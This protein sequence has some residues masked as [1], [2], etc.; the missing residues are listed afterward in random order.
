[1]LPNL[2]DVINSLSGKET[3]I[4]SEK[5][6]TIGFQW[7]GLR[8]VDYTK[9]CSCTGILGTSDCPT[10]SRCMSTGYLHVDYLVKGYMWLGVLGVEYQSNMGLLSTQAR[11]LVLSHNRP[12]NKFDFIL[13]LDQ[14]PD[15]AQVRQP[16][17]IIKYYKVQD[18]VPL[19]GD[20]G[21][22][23]FW[24]CSLEERNIKDGKPGINGAP[25]KY[26]GNRSIPSHEI[27]FT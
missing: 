23:E 19:K 18:S 10:C 11:N 24:K 5:G 2:R 4:F 8:Q 20:S 21:R 27:F 17:K 14:D 16:F 7:F 12:V 25:M 22:V 3:T 9:K 26:S 6:N 1:M 15:T 13:E